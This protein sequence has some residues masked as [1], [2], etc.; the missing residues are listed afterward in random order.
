MEKL[1]KVVKI[2]VVGVK[3]P[4]MLPLEEVTTVR[5]GLTEIEADKLCAELQAQRPAG[6]KYPD[7]G[8]YSYW[9]N[10]ERRDW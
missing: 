4:S 2:E 3:F 6:K 5:W 8:Y 10:E 9:V 7:I 1:F